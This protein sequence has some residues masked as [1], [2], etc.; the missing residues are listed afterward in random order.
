[1]IIIEQYKII[2]VKEHYEVV[3][4]R[5]YFVTSA[6]T[7]GEAQ[8]EIDAIEDA[9]YVPSS[10]RGDYGPSNPWDAPGMSVSDFI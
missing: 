9:E 4:K 6:D 3:D 8:R 1:M 7:Y 5:N 10:T 2:H